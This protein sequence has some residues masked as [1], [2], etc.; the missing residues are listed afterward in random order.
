VCFQVYSDTDGDQVVCHS[1]TIVTCLVLLALYLHTRVSQVVYGANLHYHIGCKGAH[2]YT[3]S[4]IAL[5]PH[6][7]QFETH[8]GFG[9]T[10]FFVSRHFIPRRHLHDF[11]INEGLRGWNVRYYLAAMIRSD[12]CPFAL[13][14]AY[15]VREATRIVDLYIAHNKLE[16][17]TSL[18]G[19]FGSVSRYSSCHIGEQIINTFAVEYQKIGKCV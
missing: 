18:S 14:T 6:G 8:R 3:E 13:K 11:V 12:T 16:H 4:V 1:T 19:P 7:L 5:P 10:I 15:E 9:S 17:F 2:L